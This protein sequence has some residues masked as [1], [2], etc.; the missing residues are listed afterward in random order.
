MKPLILR[1]PIKICPPIRA[2][3]ACAIGFQHIII[4]RSGAVGWG[5]VPQGGRSRVRF[6]MVS[7]RP[8]YNPGVD[9]ATNKWVQDYFL[10]SKGCRWV[11]VTTLSPSCAYCREIQEPQPPGTLRACRGV[12]MTCFAINIIRRLNNTPVIKQVCNSNFWWYFTS[13]EKE[14]TIFLLEC[15]RGYHYLFTEFSKHLLILH[16][17]RFGCIFNKRNTLISVSM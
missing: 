16:S 9:P 11:G 14:R 13:V 15:L 12:F 8:H 4:S 10:A 2:T 17:K 7:F 5:T 3:R 6:P 1:V